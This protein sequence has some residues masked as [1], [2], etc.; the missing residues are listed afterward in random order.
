M[1][2]TATIPRPE[3]TLPGAEAEAVRALYQASDVI[4]EYG[5]GGSTVMAAEMPGKT[6][7]SVESD[8]DWAQ[9]MRDW[10]KANP[11]AAGTQVDVIWSDIGPTRAWGHPAT[12]K[13]WERYARYPLGVWDLPDFRQPDA[14]LVDGRFRTGCA[15]ATAFRTQKPVTVLVDDYANRRHYHRIEAFLGRPDMIGRM[16]RFDVAPRPVPADRLVDIIEMMT[17]P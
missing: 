16:A 8:Q 17:R 9:M 5:S 11:P 14:V 4:L 13:F 1:A 3:L 7:F 2:D 10:F 6:V 15:M 12:H